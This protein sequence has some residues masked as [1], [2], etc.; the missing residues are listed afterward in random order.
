MF[1][2]KTRTSFRNSKK[3]DNPINKKNESDFDDSDID[4]N[5]SFEE[6]NDNND[7]NIKRN[8]IENEKTIINTNKNNLNNSLTRTT[9]TPKEQDDSKNSGNLNSSFKNHINNNNNIINNSKICL[10][11]DDDIYSD[12]EESVKD[13]EDSSKDNNEDNKKD[14]KIERE[15]MKS[16]TNK[17][18]V[19][20]ERIFL[21]E[22]IRFKN[23]P[24]SIVAT[25]QY[26]FIQKDD[27]NNSIKQ[28][29]KISLKSSIKLNL[30]KSSKDQLTVNAR[31]E[32]WNCMLNNYE[33]FSTNKRNILKT[34]TR[35]GIPDSLR[36]YVWQI[37]AEKKK[38]YSPNVYEDLQNQ[39][40]DEDFERTILK[41]LNR[42]FPLCHFFREQY[43]NGQRQLFRV[44]SRYSVYNKNVG[45]VQG[46]GFITAVF[47]IYMD[48]ESSFFMIHSLMKKYKMEGIY[49]DGFPELK[50]LF[51]VFLKLQKKFVNKIYNLFKKE[52]IIPTMYA[53][54]WFISLFTRS[55]EF[56]IA[57]RILDC[58]LMEGFKVIYRISLALLKIK[59]NEFCKSAKGDRLS[60]LTN[61]HENIDIDELFKI[62]F[63]FSISSSF[64]QECEEEF[65]KVKNDNNNEFISQIIW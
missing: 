65:E 25:D 45:Y 48:E 64:I 24:E 9:I 56:H 13:G 4:S 7:I 59:E 6:E 21:A 15:L 2:L 3:D 40:I 47:L 14:K 42:T 34:R 19:T 55:F 49:F 38:F 32:K 17:E 1:K 33:E 27:D 31:I 16:I 37:F 8:K 50:K 57:I 20:R 41:D 35:K 43:G 54:N 26:G 36:G 5:F 58:F 52:S 60:L 39:P 51:F 10:K 63:G 29:K 28:S 23:E 12:K 44:L 46:M 62:A 22:S 61:C 18:R 11:D 30:R 53:S